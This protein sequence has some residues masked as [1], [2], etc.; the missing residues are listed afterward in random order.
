MI[1]VP[2]PVRVLGPLVAAGA[3]LSVS[4]ARAEQ[5][6]LVGDWF[7]TLEERRA[8]HTGTLTIESNDSGLVAFVDGGPAAFK[9]SDGAVEIEFD[10]RDG[11]GQLLRYALGGR[12]DGDELKGALTPPLDAPQGTWRA[13]R[14]LESPPAPPRPVDLTGVWSRTSS[15]LA[16]VTL[17]YTPAA[18]RAV[19]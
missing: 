18:Q 4:A 13:V 9:H 5:S 14:H 11:G 8:V 3:A 17:D 10:T 2:L 12:M 7:L 1:R 15:G 16:R 6:A 19:D